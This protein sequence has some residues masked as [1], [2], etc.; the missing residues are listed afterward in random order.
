MIFEGVMEIEEEVVSD[1]YCGD[2]FV[3]NFWYVVCGFC[4]VEVL[5]FE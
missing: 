5:Y 4:I 1:D 2:V 3:V